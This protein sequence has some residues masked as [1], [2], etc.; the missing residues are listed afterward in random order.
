MPSF[1]PSSFLRSTEYIFYAFSGRHS[2]P[3]LFLSSSSTVEEV[4]ISLLFFR[5]LLAFCGELSFNLFSFLLSSDSQFPH[6]LI[7]LFFYCGV[8]TFVTDLFKLFF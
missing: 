1:F 6:F 5:H 7:W 2:L 4:V 8:F 3:P